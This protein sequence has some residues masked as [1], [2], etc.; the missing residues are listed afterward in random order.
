MITGHVFV[1]TP[2]RPRLAV[3]W[4]CC[5]VAQIVTSRNG[6]VCVAIPVEQARCAGPQPARV[7]GP[8]SD[9][10]TNGLESQ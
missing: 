4:F 1:R 9:T 3:C 7:G 8:Q 10:T 5:H 2:N 6:L